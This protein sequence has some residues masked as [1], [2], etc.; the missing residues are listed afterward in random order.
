MT[1]Q[2]LQQIESDH[3]NMAI[4]NKQKSGYDKQ[5]NQQPKNKKL[6]T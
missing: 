3:T 1:T 6:N 4:E 2:T 5:T